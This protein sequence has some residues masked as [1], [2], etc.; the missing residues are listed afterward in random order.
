MKVIHVF[1]SFK[2]YGGAQKVIFQLY[3]YLNK[4]GRNY[5]CSFDKYEDINERFL[6]SLDRNQFLHFYDLR[7]LKLRDYIIISHDRKLTSGLVLLNYLFRFKLIH[8][9]HGVYNKHKYF[10]FFPKNI[11]AVSKAVRSNL[12]DYFNVDN[13]SI[14]VIY[15]G[16]EDH[17]KK[18]EKNYFKSANRILLLGQIESNK[19][20]LEIIQN[21]DSGRNNNFKIAF[22]GEGCQSETLVQAINESAF[23]ECFD[24]LGFVEDV[25][26]LIP[27]YDY[28]MLFSKKEGLGISLIEGCMYGR[29]LVA[30]TSEGAEACGEVCKNGFNGFEVTDIVSLFDVLENLPSRDSREFMKLSK[31]SR[32]MYEKYFSESMMIHSYDLYLKKI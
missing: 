10:S 2:R 15:N 20:Q 14:E 19:Q 7:K 16:V 12:V 8:V 27:K 25:Y 9:A 21:M 28:V 18:G 13:T 32:V 30:R 6:S 23:R 22:A 26:S 11:I 31:N 4:F 5:I 3:K 1:P 24:Y 17:K 29:P